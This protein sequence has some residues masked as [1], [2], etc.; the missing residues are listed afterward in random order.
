MITSCK[1]G[2]RR[3]YE[4][5]DKG[6]TWKEALGTLSRVWSNSLAGLGLHIQSGFITAT[7]D[8]KKVILLTQL[9]YPRHDS[10]G[11]IHLWLT[12]TNRIYHVG[13]L[14]T[15]NSATSSSLLY[16]NDKLYCLYEAGVGSNSGAFFLD[17]TSE[18]QRI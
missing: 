15:G 7:I 12:D 6:N 1:Y 18:L 17:L 11:E 2:R 10:K 14:A 13:L 4:S 16:A 9:E 5:T 8:G 3:V